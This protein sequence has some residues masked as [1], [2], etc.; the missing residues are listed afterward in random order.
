[1][2]VSLRAVKSSGN[3]DY[4]EATLAILRYLGKTVT[5]HSKENVNLLRVK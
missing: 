5:S 1:M 2:S 3:A 4:L